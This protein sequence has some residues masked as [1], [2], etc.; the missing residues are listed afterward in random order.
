MIDIDTQDR[1]TFLGGSDMAAVC[2]VSPWKTPLELW[3]EKVGLQE[4]KPV[5]SFAA[6]LG[7]R[8]ERPILEM[9][10]EKLGIEEWQESQCKP[11]EAESVAN[12]V[13]AAVIFNIRQRHDLHEFVAAEADALVILE[14]GERWVID[15]KRTGNLCEWTADPERMRAP[16]HYEAQFRLQTAVFN[17][18]RHFAAV[19]PSQSWMGFHVVETEPEPFAEAALLS[20]AKGFWQNHVLAGV[21]PEPSDYA[22]A[23]LLW[24][25]NEPR[26]MVQASAHSLELIDRLRTAK[27]AKKAA[28][29]EEKSIQL[30]LAKMIQDHEGIAD[31]QGRPLVTW[32]KQTSRRIDTA[33]LK[34][35]Y[36]VTA[37]HCTKETDIRVMRLAKEAR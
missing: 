27:A 5:D 28:S 13:G 6:E 18:H 24:P 17:A 26:S 2:G 36:A 8:F 4:E 20:D 33:M 14:G 9:A 12:D 32:K 37:L 29:D 21:P 10:L 7:R 11:D 19:L 34:E 30:E 23:S 22:E 16:L 35:Q 1:T 31:E 3:R 15:A 25:L